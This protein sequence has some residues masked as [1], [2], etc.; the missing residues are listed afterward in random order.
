[1]P[2]GAR[3]CGEACG[4]AGSARQAFSLPYRA[5]RCYYDPVQ[6][7]IDAQRNALISWRDCRSARAE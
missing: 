7:G 4:P 5:M 2:L 6:E 3:V 1:M